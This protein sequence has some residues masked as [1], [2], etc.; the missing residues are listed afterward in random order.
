MHQRLITYYRSGDE[1]G[2]RG[3]G[4][5]ALA[6]VWNSER[7]SRYLTKLMHWFPAIDAFERHMQLVELDD[8]ASS[9]AAQ[10]SL[11][12]NYVGLPL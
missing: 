8:I 4:A 1:S 7:F 11:A 5:L 9:T 10:R 3:Y 12:V 2:L 6:R